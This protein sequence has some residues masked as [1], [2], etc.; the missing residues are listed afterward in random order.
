MILL[1]LTSFRLSGYPPFYDQNNVELFKQIMAGKYEFDRPWWDN[2]S[3]K[4]KNFIRHLL[5]LDPKA[6]YT[7][8]QALCHPF[9]VDHCGHTPPITLPSINTSVTSRDNRTGMLSPISTPGSQFSSIESVASR[10]QDSVSR[11]NQDST[12]SQYTPRDSVTTSW[13]NIAGSPSERAS[14]V[15]RAGPKKV[16]MLTYNIFLRPPGIKNN[17]SDHKNARHAAFGEQYLKNFDI[18][19]LQEMFSYGSSRVSRMIHYGHKHGFEF[20]VAHT[21][22]LQRSSRRRPD[23]LEQVPNHPH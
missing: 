20:Y 6:R 10:S 2:V 14:L 11:R 18:V 13:N 3:E 21:K 17:L 23:D 5:V 8:Q 12:S 15:L 9:I 16:K 7:A 22:R 4:A 19:A 1:Y